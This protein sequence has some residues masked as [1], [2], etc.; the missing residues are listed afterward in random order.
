MGRPWCFLR[1]INDGL[2]GHGA[3]IGGARPVMA[4]TGCRPRVTR[5]PAGTRRVRVACQQ[6]PLE[7]VYVEATPGTGCRAA[8]LVGCTVFQ[9]PG[10]LGEGVRWRPRQGRL[11]C[12]VVFRISVSKL[13]I[14]R[15]GPVAIVVIVIVPRGRRDAARV[16]VVVDGR[17]PSR[18][19]HGVF[20]RGGRRRLHS[21]LLDDLLRFRLHRAAVATMVV[22]I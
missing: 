9:V 19:G 8:L 12:N 7:R 17:I 21:H 22:V 2:A 16:V 14:E 11:A 15:V 13:G 6:Q 10:G 3:G 4:W 20:G 1:G 5:L 18:H